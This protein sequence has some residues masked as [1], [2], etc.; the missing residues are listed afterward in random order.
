MQPQ[1]GRS[2]HDCFRKV[3]GWGK[4]FSNSLIQ[5]GHTP[6]LDAGRNVGAEKLTSVSRLDLTPLPKRESLQGRD[7]GV[8]TCLLCTDFLVGD[9]C[10]AYCIELIINYREN[11]LQNYKAIF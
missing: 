11:G 6:T 7:Y 4:R 1:R 8:V 10:S 9:V 2:H 3:Y 5:W